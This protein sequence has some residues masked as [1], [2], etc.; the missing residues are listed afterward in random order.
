[1]IN[2]IILGLPGSGKGT[3]SA[4]LADVMG[5]HHI[6]AGSLVRQH[7]A[8]KTWAGVRAEK[9]RQAQTPLP[10]YLMVAMLRA[11]L[12]QASRDSG[13][14]LDGFPRSL[15]AQQWLFGQPYAIDIVFHLDIDHDTAIRRLAVR[16][17]NINDI[18]ERAVR[19]LCLFESSTRAVID[20]YGRLGLLRHI[21]ALRSAEDVFEHLMTEV[22][23]LVQAGV[24][25]PSGET[26]S[27]V[28]GRRRTSAPG[29]S[30]KA[31]PTRA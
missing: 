15:L 16:N 4:R 1:V 12:V 5:L 19:R 9:F 31:N 29:W 7:A 14:V 2:C 11:P 30:S 25:P 24:H 18:G 20:E 10:E 3:Q 8:T 22:R 23:P 17:R 13:F 27:V 6:D 26:W 28:K 21:E